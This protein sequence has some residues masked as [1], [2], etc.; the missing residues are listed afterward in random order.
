M[1]QDLSGSQLV[2]PVDGGLIELYRS[3][4]VIRNLVILSVNFK[5]S[6]FKVNLTL[7]LVFRFP[8]MKGQ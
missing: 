1:Q 5:T 7:F 8:L 4:H 2:V 3:K 6:L